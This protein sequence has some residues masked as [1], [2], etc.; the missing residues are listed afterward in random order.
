MGPQVSLLV[1]IF[2]HPGATFGLTRNRFLV[3]LQLH[4]EGCGPNHPQII[5]LLGI[6]QKFIL[7]P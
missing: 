2:G 6:L 1:S 5:D 3:T 4:G 7:R